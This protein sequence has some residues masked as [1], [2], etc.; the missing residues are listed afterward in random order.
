M[1][2]CEILAPAGSM[3]SVIAG[4]RS[5]ADA[6]YIG[7]KEFSARA[8][9]ENF[10]IDEIKSL[11]AY[12]RERN[13]KVYLTLNTLVFDDELKEALT[14]CQDAYKAGIDAV[15]VQDLGLAMLIKK[16]MPKLP[17]HASTQLS[18]HTPEGAK[19]LKDLGFQRVVLSRE[20]SKAEIKE[21]ADA[22][23]IELEVFVHGALCMSVSGQCYF[24]A[25]L[26]SRSGNRGRCAQPCRLPFKLKGGNGYALSLKDSSL[27]DYLK[28]LEDMGVKSAKIEG[29][30]KRPEYVSAAVRACREGLDEGKV[31]EKTAETLKS[32][33]SRTGFTDGYYKG[34]RDKNLFGYRQKEDVTSATN[35][36]L[37]EIR[38]S[39]KDERKAAG[40]SMS[41]S[42]KCDEKA[43]LTVSDGINTV[44]VYSESDAEIAKSSPSSKESV[45]RSLSKTGGTPYYLKDLSFTTDEKAIIPA[46]VLNS[47]R[48][49]ALEKIS[50]LRGKAPSAEILPVTLNRTGTKAENTAEKF[51]ARFT[52]TDVPEDFK[53]AER[54]F[55]PLFAPLNEYER[56]IKNNFNVCAEIP[57]GMFGIENQIKLRLA[58]LKK[59]GVKAVLASNI[60]AVYLAN[61]M[62]FDVHGGFGLNITNTESLV[63]YEEM[64]LKSAELSFELTKNQIKEIGGNIPRGIIAAGYLPLMLLRAC[65]NLNSSV[66][67]STCTGSTKM[68]DRLG[69]TFIL[70]C[71]GNCTEVLNSVYLSLCN[72]IDIFCGLD[73]FTFRFSVENSVEK[74]ENIRSFSSKHHIFSKI[75]R[76]LYLRGVK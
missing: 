34:K 73:F 46:S 16:S 24:S 19:A 45:E 26:G 3:E 25:M 57:R 33:F 62:G 40:L 55:L 53:E 71:D 42:L 59:I 51:T 6:V 76:G 49:E 54:I 48:R 14:L 13:V 74:V 23:D 29:R 21:I 65:P 58:E 38:N 11:C 63:A 30:M 52:D 28:E 32:V 17:L 68:Q 12:C 41:L 27:V 37:S 64:G 36:L 20:L 22:T 18:V 66:K 2:K 15:I 56:L 67:C 60:G 75:T 50:L 47:M 7:A 35:K 61:K 72:E 44:T 9:A 70:K 39:Y 10:S 5:G 69:E 1:N 43:E 8:S 4:V 31:S